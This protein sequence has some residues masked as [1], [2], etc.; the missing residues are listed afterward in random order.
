MKQQP[1]NYLYEQ[2]LINLTRQ[3][4]R[5]ATIGGDTCAVRLIQIL[6]IIS[7]WYFREGLRLV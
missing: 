7:K 6:Q 1:F 4:K 2:Y 3:G 5:S